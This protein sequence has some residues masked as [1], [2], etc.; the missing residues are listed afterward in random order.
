M[1]YFYKFEQSYPRDRKES[2]EERLKRLEKL[3]TQT[4][5]E[6]FSQEMEDVANFF[7]LYHGIR[8]FGHEKTGID[9]LES[10]I[11]TGYILPGNEINQVFNS[12]DGTVKYLHHT[13]YDEEKCNQD[14]YISVAPFLPFDDNNDD[15]VNTFIKEN[16]HLKLDCSIK[17][18]N[19]YYLK[20]DDYIRLRKSKIPTKNFYSYAMRE[21]F[22]KE[23]IPID[24]ILAICIDPTHYRGNLEKTIQEIQNILDYYHVNIPL[25]ITDHKGL[26]L[27]RIRSLFLY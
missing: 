22:V 10:I 13:K 11:Q 12:Y 8:S 19:T 26:S 27:S 21:Y 14:R 17:A 9:K 25:E 18:F 5:S 16:I 7:S 15:E 4:F 24:K 1:Y 3:P 2:F 23:P 20:Y 6:E